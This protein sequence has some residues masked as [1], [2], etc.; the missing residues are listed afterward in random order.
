MV[1]DF[2]KNELWKISALQVPKDRLGIHGLII[3]CREKAINLSVREPLKVSDSE[4]NTCIYSCGW[5]R[6]FC[7]E[8]FSGF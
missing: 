4:W 8:Y 3:A 2:G 6:N 1:I 7:D 5:R